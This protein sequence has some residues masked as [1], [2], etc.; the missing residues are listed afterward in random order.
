MRLEEKVYR[1]RRRCD[2]KEMSNMSS[3]LNGSNL[4]SEAPL[5]CTGNEA[6]GHD[7]F[8][9]CAIFSRE[10]VALIILMRQRLRTQIQLLWPP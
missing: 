6:T 8:V 2:G 7:V 3:A 10:R 1:P 5:T 9:T 4:N